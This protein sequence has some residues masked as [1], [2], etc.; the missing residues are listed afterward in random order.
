MTRTEV[1]RARVTP[2]ERELL[3]L[4]AQQEERNPSQMLRRLLREA[5]RRRGIPLPDWTQAQTQQEATQ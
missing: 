1:I 3:T 4:I 5:A 2:R